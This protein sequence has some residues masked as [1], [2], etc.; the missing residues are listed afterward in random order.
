MLANWGEFE[1]S[2]VS[3]WELICF[4]KDEGLKENHKGG[5]GSLEMTFCSH[6]D[7]TAF[8]GW[9]LKLVK[10]SLMKK[11]L[12]EEFLTLVVILFCY[13]LLFVWLGFFVDQVLF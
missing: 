1:E 10:C 12:V 8:R 13:Q 6:K 3:E 2:H 9:K 7:V 11:G 4:P 5:K